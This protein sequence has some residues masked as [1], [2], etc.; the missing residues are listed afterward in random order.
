MER[1]RKQHVTYLTSRMINGGSN[2]NWEKWLRDN[3]ELDLQ[4][5]I[6]CVERV[7]IVCLSGTHASY[8]GL[9]LILM[10]RDAQ[11]IPGFGIVI[12]PSTVIST[13]YGQN[14]NSSC[15]WY[16]DGNISTNKRSAKK[17][18]YNFNEIWT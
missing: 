9:P 15:S 17:M 4:R 16:A 14:E 2:R 5:I 12:E 7:M 13:S 3:Q 11:Q 10:F 1:E 6:N 8:N 18:L